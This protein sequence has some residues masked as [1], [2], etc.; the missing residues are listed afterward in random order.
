MSALSDTNQIGNCKTSKKTD[1]EAEFDEMEI[2][3]PDSYD[4]REQYPHCVQP[5]HDIGADRNCSA[6]YAMAT[7]GVV[8]DRICMG[9]NQTVRL[10]SQ[11][12]I[13]CDDNEFGCEGGYANK[14]LTWG[15][16][17]GFITEECHEYK[18]Q[19]NEC[20][21]DHLESNQ[22]RIENQIYK[23]NDFCL[24]MQSDSIKR[25]IVTNGPI[26]GQMQ[27]YTDFL[28]Y[29]EGTYHKT[30]ESFKFNGYHIVKIIGWSQSIDGSDE[31]IVENSWGETWGEN[32]YARIVGG[33]GDTQI[34]FYGLGVSVVPYTLYDYYSMQNMAN[35]VN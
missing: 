17:K 30:P 29:K 7:L 5:V 6:S 18:G 33:R 16:K 1:P 4:W 25:E 27:P 8:E 31:W 10:S 20:E 32:G 3:V 24:A 2:E 19:K 14:V 22:C 35:S 12:I 13:D 28:A 23:V 21:I 11:E 34:D 9:S 26:I 15:K